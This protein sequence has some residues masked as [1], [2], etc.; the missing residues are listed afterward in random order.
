MPRTDTIA[1]AAR[2]PER[3]PIIA[4]KVKS[5]VP[6]F[7]IRATPR[8]PTTAAQPIRHDIVSPSHRKAMG[9]M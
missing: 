4:A 2:K 1:T 6:G 8:N 7:R 9:A 5:P 3:A